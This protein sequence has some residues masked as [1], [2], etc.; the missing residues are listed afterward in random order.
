MQAGPLPCHSH[1]PHWLS[2]LGLCVALGI[3]ATAAF[4]LH[5]AYQAARSRHVRSATNLNHLLAETLVQNIEQIRLSMEDAKAALDIPALGFIPDAIRH[6]LFFGR[7]E[8]ARDQGS[9][10]VIDENG[11]I[12]ADAEA[13]VP[14]TANFADRDYFKVHKERPNAGFY[15]SEPF[16]GRLDNIPFLGFSIRVS[17]P[18]GAFKG[19]VMGT[20]RLAYLQELFSRLEVDAMTTITLSR[21]GRVVARHPYIPD[22]IGRDLTGTN[23][24]SGIGEDPISVFEGSGSLDGIGRIYV[25]AP[26]GDLPLRITI[27]LAKADIFRDW[28]YKASIIGTLTLALMLA[29]AVLV[30]MF[31]RE[32][33]RRI[34]A[35]QEV[36]ETNRKLVE[37]SRLD[38]IT[39]IAHRGRFDI[40]LGEAWRSAKQADTPLS[41]VL[42]DIEYFRSFNDAFG[43]MHGDDVLRIMAEA[44]KACLPTPECSVARFSGKEFIML[45]PDTGPEDAAALTVAVRETVDKLLI[46]H[47]SSPT[48]HLYISTGWICSIQEPTT[49]PEH[50]LRLVCG[51]M[52]SAKQQRR[53]TAPQN[54][55]DQPSMPRQVWK[56]SPS[57][58]DT[59]LG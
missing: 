44:L 3:G 37:L 12:L 11:D 49:S 27:G 23:A 40:L 22:V 7:I 50:M 55:P 31:Q 30:A 15:V 57:A 53:Q 1:L 6:R 8:A 56:V 9:I 26:V 51:Q 58:T 32:I 39:G 43:R 45:L 29:I 35:E 46:E 41:L 18:D 19:I 42:V 36:A 13:P 10:L 5:D 2:A 28:A 47:P 17:G 21:N 54:L 16:L 48:G 24:L 34:T 52:I 4:A 25:A 14:R 33:R 38:P 59:V 20:L